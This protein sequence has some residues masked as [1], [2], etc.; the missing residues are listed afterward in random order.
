M[1]MILLI[2]PIYLLSPVISNV[3]RELNSIRFKQSI[4]Q[5]EDDFKVKAM[6]AVATYLKAIALADPV[7]CTLGGASLS[8]TVPLENSLEMV[9]LN[10]ATV[11]PLP[12]ID[13]ND[14]NDLLYVEAFNR[15][16]NAST[17]YQTSLLPVSNLKTKDGTYFC[18]MIRPSG[19]AAGVLG[20]VA[21]NRPALVEF[22]FVTH[23]LAHDPASPSVLTCPQLAPL[24]PPA[25]IAEPNPWPKNVVGGLYYTVHMRSYNDGTNSKVNRHY[26]SKYIS[27]NPLGN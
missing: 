2:A 8:L 10:S 25:S 26:T 5:V 20:T 27:A 3:G 19:G 18:A 7:D 12:L 16:N 23:D 4:L 15:C 22:L 21:E 17:V 24:I 13:R 1:A 14:T 6:R 9:L 11:A